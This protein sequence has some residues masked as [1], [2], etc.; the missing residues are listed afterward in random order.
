MPSPAK[1]KR[2]RVRA[3]G[4]KHHPHLIP[5]MQGEEL[6]WDTSKTNRWR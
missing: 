3:P 2:Y 1:W 5:P 4:H 6:E